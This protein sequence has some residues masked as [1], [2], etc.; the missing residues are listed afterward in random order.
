[1]DDF[2]ELFSA[3]PRVNGQTYLEHVTEGFI[4]T[5]ELSVMTMVS[6]TNTFY[7][8]ILPTYV[9]RRLIKLASKV[10]LKDE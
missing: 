5:L 9:K 1:M 2:F 3:I 6:L 8:F 7:P 10:D 4:R